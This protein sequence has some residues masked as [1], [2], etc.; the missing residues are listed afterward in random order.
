MTAGDKKSPQPSIFSEYS[1]KMKT[2]A[3]LLM[4][5]YLS[6]NMGGNTAGVPFT[7]ASGY[8]FR[9]NVTPPGNHYLIIRS[10]DDFDKY[11]GAAALMGK[12]GQPTPID[13]SRQFV[14]A[15]VE[16]ETY[17]STTI[18]T[19]ELTVIADKLHLRYDVK[20]EQPQ[21]FSAIPVQLL[22]IDRQYDLK[23]TVT[24]NITR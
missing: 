8:F 20:M 7:V 15:I 24:R 14:I 12:N 5:T 9:N 17:T 6:C 11:F 1:G 19:H 22:I 4:L 3:F 13:F 10:R 23:L 16:G 18:I 21:S 2:I